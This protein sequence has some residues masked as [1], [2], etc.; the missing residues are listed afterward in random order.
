ML[1][2]VNHLLVNR[3]HI[4]PGCFHEAVLSSNA[5]ANVQNT[6]PEAKRAVIIRFGKA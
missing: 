5:D 3:V 4:E 1:G 2:T 6:G